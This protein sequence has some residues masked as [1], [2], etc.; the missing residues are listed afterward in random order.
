MPCVERLGEAL[1][2]VQQHLLDCARFSTQ[3]R[4]GIA[5]PRPDRADQLVEERLPAAPS[6]W[7]WRQARRRMRRNT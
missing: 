3:F 1:F 2:L 5:H 7:P 6:L 4:V